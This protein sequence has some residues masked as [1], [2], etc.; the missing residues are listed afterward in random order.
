MMPY[1]GSHSQRET[2]LQTSFEN[3]F[4]VASA[5]FNMP[6]TM[7]SQATPAAKPVLRLSRVRSAPIGQSFDLVG[8]HYGWPKAVE[9]KLGSPTPYQVGA[10]GGEMS[11][12]QPK[13]ADETLP[14]GPAPASK[15]SLNKITWP[16]VGRVAEP[17]RYMFK[18]GWLTVTDEDLAVWEK[19][20]NAEF[21]LYPMVTTE[22]GEEFRLGTFDLRTYLSLSEK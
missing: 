19:Y 18:F 21:T 20:P 6:A 11:N 1:R 2:E 16:Q 14:P 10:E 5:G 22:A 4:M 9:I 7:Q 15:S 13:E 8:N 17:G 3:P 12:D